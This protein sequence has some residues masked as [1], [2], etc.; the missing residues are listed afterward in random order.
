MVKRIKIKDKIMLIDDEDFPTVDAWTWHIN[1]GY[2]ERIDWKTQKNISVHRL[3]M[4]APKGKEVDHINGE[5]L[6]NRKVNLRICSPQEN[7]QNSRLRKDNTTG[8]KGVR[9]NRKRFQAYIHYN[10]FIHL[11]MFDSPKDAAVEYNKA[12]K[13]YFG[14]FAKLNMTVL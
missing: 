3:V 10:G 12:A 11:G 5:K 7:R 1:K 4:N 6:D 9:R 2:A 13:K 14:R 8:F